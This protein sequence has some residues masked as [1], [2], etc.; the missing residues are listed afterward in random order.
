MNV[1]RECDRRECVELRCVQQRA[2]ARSVGKMKSCRDC[3]GDV[4]TAQT[5][6]KEDA[7]E[8]TER[9]ETNGQIKCRFQTAWSA[10]L[11]C[12]GEPN[13]QYQRSRLCA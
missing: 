12:C 2:D 13:R 1:P 4:K 9:S 3:V 10:G 7:K 5:G 6:V 8:K 11:L